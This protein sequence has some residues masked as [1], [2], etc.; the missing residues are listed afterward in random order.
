MTTTPRP[1]LA[2]E[3][4]LSVSDKELMSILAGLRFLQHIIDTGEIDNYRDLPY[5][6]ETEPL[7]SKEIDT[8]C[9]NLNLS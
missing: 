9:E 4:A 2:K 3:S 8:L 1:V 7:S 5:F 6:D